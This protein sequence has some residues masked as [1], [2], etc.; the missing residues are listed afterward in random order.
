MLSTDVGDQDQK[1]EVS[2]HRL[3]SQQHEHV[4]L[5]YKENTANSCQHLLASLIIVNTQN[6]ANYDIQPT[7]CNL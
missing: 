1:F 2:N 3:T 5:G 4:K 6:S 7:I